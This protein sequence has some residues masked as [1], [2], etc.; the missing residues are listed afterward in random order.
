MTIRESYGEGEFCWVDLSSK[1]MSAAKEWYGAL[2]GWTAEDGDTQGGPPY[3]QL[4][5]DGKVVAGL[6]QLS[7]EMQAQGVPPTWN[8]Y[9]S[10]KDAAA[11][12][13][14]VEAAGGKV[15]APAMQ[16]LEFGSM[17][18]FADPTGAVFAVW[19]PGSHFGAQLCNAPGSFCWNELAT[20]DLDGAK[21]FYEEIFGWDVSPMDGPSP[22]PMLMIRNDGRDNGDVIQ[23]NEQWEGIPPHWMVYFAVDD[24]DATVAKA[25]ELGGQVHVPP[26]EIPPGRFSVIADAQGAVFSV[27]QLSQPPG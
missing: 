11:T 21:T 2:F 9:V 8:S 7:D 13:A 20:R 18:F 23:M 22:H 24:I 10:V 25:K 17:G 6:G 12:Q 3:A 4:L 26:T 15:V 19:Q 14:K 5:K 16:I 1:D 27:I